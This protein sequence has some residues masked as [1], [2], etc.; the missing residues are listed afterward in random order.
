MTEFEG[1]NNPEILTFSKGNVHLVPR[2]GEIDRNVVANRVLKEQL[3]VEEQTEILDDF[4]RQLTKTT[5]KEVLS[6]V[7]LEGAVSSRGYSAQPLTETRLAVVTKPDGLS[8]SGR[9][10]FSS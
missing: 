2:I 6:V 4:I 5:G 10:G 7:P 3:T 8:S 9:E 1:H